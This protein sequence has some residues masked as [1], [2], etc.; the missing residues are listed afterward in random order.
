MANITII[1]VDGDSVI[2][3]RPMEGRDIDNPFSRNTLE[4]DY[5][6]Q[7]VME[8]WDVA[9]VYASELGADYCR[10]CDAPGVLTL[11]EDPDNEGEWAWLCPECIDGLRRAS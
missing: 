7:M 6:R 3:E 8:E 4:R 5:R 10:L 11:T 1:S 9:D 2:I